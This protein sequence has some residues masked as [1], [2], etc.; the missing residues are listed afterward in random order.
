MGCGR[1][2]GK[3]QVMTKMKRGAVVIGAGPAGLMAAGELARAGLPVTL[4]E[5]KP[6]PARK[7]LMAGKSGLNLT[8]SEPL[9]D[10]L[11]AYDAPRMREI[12]AGFGPEAVQDWAR[13]LGQDL[14]TGS[15]GRVFPEVMKASP[16]LRAWLARLQARGVVLRTRWR[17]TGWDGDA[18]L[19][20]TPEGRQVLRPAVTVLA[21]GGASWARLGSDGAWA[22]W[23]RDAGVPVAPFE[24]ANM[25]FVVDWSAPMARHFGQ[26]VKGV[27]L[28]A[29]GQ[30]VR[31]EFVISERGLE[32]GGIYA[33]SRALREG[34]PL[35]IDLLPDW[36][37]GKV[38]DRLARPRGK[39]SLSNHLRKALR[40]DPV[41]LALLMEFGRPLPAG[42]ALA[43]RVKNLPVR[44]AGP[45]PMDEAISTAG[46]VAW[47]GLDKGLMLTARPGT[48]CAG[49]MLDWEAPTGGY[50]LTG[51]LATGR[52]AGRAAAQS[53]I[54][55][56]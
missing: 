6:S 47:D 11:A 10:F 18:V 20:D 30:R 46:G 40:L 1:A 12:V 3:G 51:C 39:A 52:H 15:S 8:K 54:A 4:A 14:F 55:R 43:E 13:D 29:G 28:V 2:D 42:A 50:L 34:A 16:L 33:V 23:L 44:H 56:R 9:A 32:G 22:A 49:E 35:A 37:V 17:W 36:P 21:L 41:R 53:A 26:P 45:R 48:W 24:P 7:F 27:A 25:G 38:A 31:G 19:F 5:A